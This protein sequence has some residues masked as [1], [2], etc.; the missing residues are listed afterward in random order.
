MFRARID[1]DDAKAIKAFLTET[2]FYLKYIHGGIYHGLGQPCLDRK[3]EIVG[4]IT[5]WVRA[6]KSL[7]PIRMIEREVMIDSWFV[8]AT[9]LQF[10]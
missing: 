6:A 2:A 5:I 1:R 3:E 9:E 10:K 4:D 7:S 8:G